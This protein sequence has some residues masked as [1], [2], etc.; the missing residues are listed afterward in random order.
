MNLY[1]S[2]VAIS[3]SQFVSVLFGG[4]PDMTVASRIFVASQNGSTKAQELERI[5]NVIFF[6][7]DQHCK[8]A[9][10]KDVAHAS[11]VFHMQKEIKDA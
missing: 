2:N 9:W 10:L 4:H 5:L 1:R 8:Q 3:I 11:K 7:D 6:W